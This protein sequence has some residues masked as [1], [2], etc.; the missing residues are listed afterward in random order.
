[1]IALN[2]DEQSLIER[3]AGARF[4]LSA[5]VVGE[6]YYGVFNSQR[7]AENLARLETALSKQIILPCTRDTG[8]EFGLIRSEL[9]AKGRPI[10]ENDIWIAA[11]AREHQLTLVTRDAHFAHISNLKTI[12]W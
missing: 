3:L 4:A 11:S 7:A 6:L 1:V 12:D 8:R 2:D 10:P 5:V 9:K